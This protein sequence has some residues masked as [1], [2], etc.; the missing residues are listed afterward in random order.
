M[1]LFNRDRAFFLWP[2]RAGGVLCGDHVILI[3]F[4]LIL[5][6]LSETAAGR[7]AGEPPT[8]VPPT[9]AFSTTSSVVIVPPLPMLVQAATDIPG[10]S[11]ILSIPYIAHRHTIYAPRNAVAV[12]VFK[13]RFLDCMHL[14]DY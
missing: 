1:L 6:M 5:R 11:D 13:G 9:E 4:V 2:I 8:E 12:F 3:L 10:S 7:C 14:I